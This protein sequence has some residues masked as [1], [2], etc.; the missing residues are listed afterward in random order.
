MDELREQDVMEGMVH[1]KKSSTT[2]RGRSVLSD[3]IADGVRGNCADWK[4]VPTPLEDQDLKCC[5]RVKKL[6]SL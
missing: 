3:E 2:M 6:L 4:E 1:M 5:T